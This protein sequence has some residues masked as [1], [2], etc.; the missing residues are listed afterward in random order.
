MKNHI[1]AILFSLA[2]IITAV[3]FSNAFKYKYKQVETVSVTGLAEHDFTSDL[4]VWEGN[5]TRKSLNIKEAYSSLKSD[6]QKIRS[7]L[8]EKGIND[9]EIVF[10]AINTTKDFDTYYDNNGNPRSTFSGFVLSQ[11]IEIESN[12]LSKIEKI[13]R[14]ITELLDFGIEFNSSQPRYYYTKLNELKID[15][16]AQATADGKLRA[17]TIANN[18]GSKL[19]QLKKASMGIFQITGKN[20][21]EDYSWGG[22]FNTSSKNKTA[23]ITIRMEFQI[24]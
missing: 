24:R 8:K 4:I 11:S 10:S 12:N 9:N 2:I 19:G 20:S 16:L 17:E 5:F 22:V 15:L 3:L 13:S 23:S 1:G 7:Y 18:S 14:E 6:E 21:N